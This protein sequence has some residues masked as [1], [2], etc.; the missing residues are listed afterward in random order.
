LKHPGERLAEIAQL[1][2]KARALETE[3]QQRRAA[4]REL[5]DFLENA[6]EGLHKVGA[7]ACRR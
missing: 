1:Q 6:L 2:Q 4:Q 3:V 5:V 7:D